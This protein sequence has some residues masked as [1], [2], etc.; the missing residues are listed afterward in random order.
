MRG[1]EELAQHQFGRL[2]FV[3]GLVTAGTVSDHFILLR[4]WFCFEQKLL[5][6]YP[7]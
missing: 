5:L 3:D 2:S 7:M 1:V 6:I 4:Y